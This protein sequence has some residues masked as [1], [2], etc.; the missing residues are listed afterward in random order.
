MSKAEQPNN[1][2]PEDRKVVEEFFQLFKTPWEFYD[3]NRGRYE[4]LL[5]ADGDIPKVDADLVVVYGSEPGEQ[6]QGVV[7]E[8]RE[9][10]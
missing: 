9:S 1:S 5:V 6:E 7:Y 4:V 8:S 10:H 3:P 2:I